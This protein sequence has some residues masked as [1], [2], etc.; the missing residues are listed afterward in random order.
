MKT[1]AKTKNVR[2]V[3]IDLL[4]QIEKNQAY[5]NLLLHQAIKQHQV[6]SKD[7][8][9][10]TEMVYG[11]LQRKLTLDFYIEPYLKKQNKLEDWVKILLRITVYQ[12][13]Y[14][15]RVPDRAAI[16][17]AVEIAK[18]KGHKG[19][20]S[21]VNGVLRSLQ[22]TGFRSFD[23]VQDPIERLAIEMSFPSWL[24]SRWVKQYGLEETK[25]LC[26]ETLLPP[27][28]SAR[29]NTAVTTAE[30]VMKSMEEAGVSTRTGNL[31]DDALI[32]ERGNFAN[33][34]AYQDGLLTIQDESS[35]LV[36]RALGPEKDDMILDSCAAPGGKST[37][38]AELLRNTG[39][40]ISVDLHEHKIKLINEQV[41]RLHLTNVE[42]KVMDSR[43]LTEVY[44]S[45]TFD[46]ILVDAPCSGLG[47]IRRK[48]DI[49]YQKNESDIH[50]LAGIQSTILD[51]IAPL[52]KKGGTLVYST[53]TMDKEENDEVV[54]KFLE[55]HPDFERDSMLVERLPEKIRGNAEHNGAQIQILPHHFG[56]DGFFIS[57]LRKQV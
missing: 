27:I 4:V 50:S 41:N 48:P 49:K 12:M 20:G 56:T 51:A 30:E 26:Q 55:S 57:S 23:E 9:L 53:C 39:K 37:H 19:I 25:E 3:A 15:D 38:I 24:I 1:T 46:R 32:I 34:A 44:K 36:G 18:R 2:E 28:S 40:V 11:T 54:I 7:T 8:G 31:S 21:M 5:S 10:L 35:M 52:L 42:T 33:T 29:I 47:V 16:F 45:E 14:L 43:K 13:K 22:R 17:E 6:S